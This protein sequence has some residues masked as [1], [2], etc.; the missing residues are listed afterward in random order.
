[1]ISDEEVYREET[2]RM[3]RIEFENRLIRRLKEG[4]EV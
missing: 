3:A 4:F 1:M 2:V